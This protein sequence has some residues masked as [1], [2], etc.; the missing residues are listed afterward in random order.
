MIIIVVQ[1]KKGAER[2]K[3]R[4]H[5]KHGMKRKVIDWCDGSSCLYTFF[6]WIYKYFVWVGYM[7]DRHEGKSRNKFSWDK[8][9][10]HMTAPH[11]ITTSYTYI[12]VRAFVVFIIHVSIY[13]QTV[14]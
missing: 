7:D 9:M 2:E 5:T 4:A 3:K 12:A 6:V 13:E 11:I 1:R 10:K 8:P 14:V